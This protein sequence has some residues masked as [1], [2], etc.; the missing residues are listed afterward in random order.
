PASLAGAS[1]TRVTRLVAPSAAAAVVVD[2]PQPASAAAALRRLGAGRV[3]VAVAPVLGSERVLSESFV[4]AAGGI[5][6]L[7]A[8]QG[9]SSV[10]T[11]SRDAIAYA[12][13]VGVLYQGER[14]TLEGLRGYATGLALIDGVHDGIGA[15]QIAHRLTR[16]APFTDALVAP[17]RSDAP[18]AG[19]P[20]L[21]VVGPTFLPATL[22]PASTGGETYSGRYFADGAWRPLG[23]E[24]YGPSLRAPVPPLR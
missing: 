6:R 21:A 11:Q 20:R 23:S 8:V 13:T 19:S 15:D 10:G 12:G 9:T 14:P 3:R 18:A 4:R 2:T 16:P 1:R 22:I 17:W 7:G 5:G 24:L